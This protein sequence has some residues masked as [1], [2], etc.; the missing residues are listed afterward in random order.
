MKGNVTS[1]VKQGP[2]PYQEDRYYETYIPDRKWRLLVVMD[3]H[4]GEGVA[5]FCAKNIFRMIALNEGKPEHRLNSLVADLNRSTRQYTVGSTFSGVIISEE[6][7]TASVAI[8]GDSPVVIYDKQGR[9]HTSP[10]HNVR[11][12]L[13]E[14]KAAEERG[15]IYSGGYIWSDLSDLAQGLQIS[16]ALGDAHL[17]GILS[18]EP[19]IYT[20]AE[21]VWVLVASDGLFDPGHSD[22]PR[23]VEEV[24][25]FAKRNATADELME[26]A[27]KRGLKDNA[28]ALVWC[29]S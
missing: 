7:N 20:I 29:A 3:G 25:E 10:E 24:R 6:L 8:L 26:W 18:R 17:D 14:R 11:S 15:G 21:P 9:L 2:R 4:G 19:E 27:E 5:G 23:L 12:N 13:E 28:T 1:A 16:R 22:T